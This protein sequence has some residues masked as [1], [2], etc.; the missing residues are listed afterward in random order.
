MQ[1]A[2]YRLPVAMNSGSKLLMLKIRSGLGFQAPVTGAR[3]LPVN[4]RKS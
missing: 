2:G 1:V 4:T 3:L